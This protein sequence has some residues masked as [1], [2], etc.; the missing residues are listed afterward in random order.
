MTQFRMWT[1]TAALLLVVSAAADGAEKKVKSAKSTAAAEQTAYPI[2]QLN[3]STDLLIDTITKSIKPKSWSSQGGQ[4][5]IYRNPFGGCL[6]VYQTP[7]VQKQ[8]ACLLRGLEKM[9]AAPQDE[10]ACLGT[11]LGGC[12]GTLIGSVTPA[13]YTCVSTPAT[14]PACKAS[15]P[16]KQYGHFVMDNVKVN[17]MGVSATIKR[18][19][20]MYKGDGIDADVAKCALTNGDTEIRIEATPPAPPACLAGSAL[21]TCPAPCPPCPAPCVCVPM[22]YAAPFITSSAVCPASCNSSCVPCPA[23]RASSCAACPTP[24]CPCPASCSTPSEKKS[25][26]SEEKKDDDEPK[27]KKRKFNF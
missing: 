6:V 1:L 7:E 27:A 18:I 20:F 9:H 15:V 23:P 19:R 4:G 12:M 10:P 14:C 2:S 26:K 17:A 13:S 5:T 3:V 24:C 16:C 25:N 11:A 8:V 22:S 21:G